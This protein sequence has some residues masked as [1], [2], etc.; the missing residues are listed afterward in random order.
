MLAVSGAGACL[1][2][3]RAAAGRSD[4]RTA[5]EKIKQPIKTLERVGVW[6][7]EMCMIILTEF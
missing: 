6:E 1:T 3:M 4:T 5:I 7:L 2:A